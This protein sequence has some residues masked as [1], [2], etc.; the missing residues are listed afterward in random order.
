MHL[1]HYNT[2]FSSYSAAIASGEPDAI[3]VIGVFYTV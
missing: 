3:A 2:K 1:V